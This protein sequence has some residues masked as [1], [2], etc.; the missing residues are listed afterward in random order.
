MLVPDQVCAAQV[1]G[2]G[3]SPREGTA[4]GPV[5]GCLEGHLCV[6]LDTCWVRQ[7]E[8]GSTVYWK[9][10]KC[11]HKWGKMNLFSWIVLC[12]VHQVVESCVWNIW[13]TVHVLNG[14][15]ACSA[16]CSN[17]PNA[18]LVWFKRLCLA[19][20]LVQSQPWIFSMLF[21]CFVILKCVHEGSFLS[22]TG[23]TVGNVGTQDPARN[24]WIIICIL[25]SGVL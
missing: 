8:P 5:W 11:P 14:L 7:S 19:S 22:I 6:P 23:E 9:F 1:I 15:L 3:S 24:P 25:K 10:K 12:V 13:H 21:H 17:V 16:E 2:L 4:V 18:L 20:S